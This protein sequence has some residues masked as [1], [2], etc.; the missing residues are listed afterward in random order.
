MRRSSRSLRATLAT[1]VLWV[2]MMLMCPT[3]RLFGAGV[4]ACS[5]ALAAGRPGSS[6]VSTGWRVR[7]SEPFVVCLDVSFLQPYAG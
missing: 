7:E 1:I 5:S 6:N 3:P 2:S 4:P